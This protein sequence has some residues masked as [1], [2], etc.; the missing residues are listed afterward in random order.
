MTPQRCI[1]EIQSV[2][3]SRGER[4]R[5]FD[6]PISKHRKEPP[7]ETLWTTEAFRGLSTERKADPVWMP[8]QT[9]T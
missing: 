7:G 3:T 5:V 8:S 9:N 1:S 6:D 2:E 4:T